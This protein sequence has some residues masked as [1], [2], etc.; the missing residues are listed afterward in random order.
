MFNKFI[1]ATVLLASSFTASAS[2]TRTRVENFSVESG[3]Q[4]KVRVNGGA[5]NVRIGSP[6]Q[7][8]VELKQVAGTNSEK[9]ADDLIAEA[10]P[11]IEKSGN[12][13]RIETK[14]GQSNFHWFWFGGNHGIRFDVDLVVPANVNLFLDTSGG[15]IKVDGEVQGALNADTS[16]GAITVT[17]ATGE[18]HLDTSGGSISVDRVTHQLSA[19]TS[20]GSI[21]VG[22]VGPNVVDVN[23]DTSGG[24]I[25]IGL[26]SSGN[27]DLYA[28]TSGGNVNVS[29]LMFNPTRKSRTHAEGKINKGGIRVRAD[30]SGGNVEIHSANP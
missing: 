20:G 12:T 4:I 2:I 17:G 13:V 22:Y 1:L 3:A 15:S 25:Q 29:D 19:D 8:H 7:V 16:G 24:N 21:H 6:G 9:E 30:T 28:D 27:Y 14:P 26:D 18:L 23:A 10:G 5:I 11:I